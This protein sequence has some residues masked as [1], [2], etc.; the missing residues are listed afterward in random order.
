MSYLRVGV[1]IFWAI[2]VAIYMAVMKTSAGCPCF[3]RLKAGKCKTCVEEFGHL[4]MLSFFTVAFGCAVWSLALGLPVF[5]D[6]LLNQ[7][8]AYSLAAVMPFPIFYFKWKKGDPREWQTDKQKK[9]TDIV[10][11]L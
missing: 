7:C 4:T 10:S 8:I 5:T 11:Y 2:W 3:Q 6:W 9:E 1:S